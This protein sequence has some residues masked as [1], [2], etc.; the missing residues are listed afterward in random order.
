M[1][2]KDKIS[3]WKTVPIL[4]ALAFSVLLF[5]CCFFVEETISAL[6]FL[7]NYIDAGKSIFFPFIPRINLLF[8]LPEKAQVLPFTFGHL[9][10]FIILVNLSMVIN[11][12]A[13]P[14]YKKVSNEYQ[15]SLFYDLPMG[16]IDQRQ[17]PICVLLNVSPVILLNRH[18]TIDHAKEADLKHASIRTGMASD[19]SRDEETEHGYS[20]GTLARLR[21]IFMEPKYRQDREPPITRS[22]SLNRSRER[23]LRRDLRPARFYNAR[24]AFASFFASLPTPS[25]RYR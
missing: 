11:P 1:S 22:S 2:Q 13:L 9:L 4:S 14:F 7:A 20:V 17:I 16:I 15:N 19:R 10:D 6:P 18:K 25:A 5:V 3:L 8:F 23:L 24:A 21:A 12:I